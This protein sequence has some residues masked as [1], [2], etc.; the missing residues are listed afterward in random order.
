M[1]MSASTSAPTSADDKLDFKKIFPIFVVVMIDLLGLTIIIPLLPLYATSFHASPFVIGLLGATYPVMQFIAAPILGRLSDRY[2]RRPILII[3]QLGTLIGFLLLGFANSLVLLFVSRI[4]DGFSGGNISTVQAMIADST[5]EK[6]R[7]Q[8]L[9][10]IGAAFGLGFIVGPVLAFVALTLSGNSY[11]VLGF[12]AAAFSAL[13]I[14]LSWFWLR[15]THDPAQ[16]STTPTRA[17]FAPSAMFRVLARPQVGLLFMLM[18]AQQ[19]SFGG[20]EQFLPLLTLSRLGL[21][22]SGNAALFLYI[23][24]IVVIIQGGLI[25]RW[26]RKW[27]DR[28]LI[29]IGLTALA[30]GLGLTALTPAQP[31]PWY[32]RAAVQRELHMPQGERTVELPDE[33]SAGWLGLGWLLVAMIPASL[34]GGILPPSINSLITKRVLPQQRG[35]MLGTSSAFA[36]GANVLAP[37]VGGALFQVFSIGAPFWLWTLTL[38]LLVAAALRALRPGREDQALVTPA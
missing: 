30:L 5:T 20:F 7:T 23:G 12:I 8:G 36:S 14:L 10:L 33:R 18:F 6:T 9:G 11:S 29:F 1:S 13:S 26:S 37:L 19:F 4:I 21:N 27:G 34:G 32:S 22:A 31:V 3:S 2:G 24:V 28:K 25:G 35:E 15:E 16:R 38:A 17:A